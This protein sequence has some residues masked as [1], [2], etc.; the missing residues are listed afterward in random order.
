MRRR[1]RTDRRRYCAA[2]F[3]VSKRSGTTDC[4][5]EFPATPVSR[6]TSPVISALPGLG[7]HSVNRVGWVENWDVA[8]E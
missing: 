1:V 5:R 7:R 3:N 2:S 4:E 6:G 8:L